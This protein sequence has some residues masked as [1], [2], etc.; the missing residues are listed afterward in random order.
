MHFLYQALVK[1]LRC[2]VSRL[3]CWLLFLFPRRLGWASAGARV[4]GPGRGAGRGRGAF[5]SE[6][7]LGFWRACGGGAVTNKLHF[8]RV[9]I[10]AVVREDGAE[11]R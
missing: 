8:V 1:S 4:G 5:P 6:T 7:E 9:L 10:G 3:V 11:S 2:L